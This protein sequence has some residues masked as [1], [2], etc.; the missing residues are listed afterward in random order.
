MVMNQTDYRDQ[1]REM[2]RDEGVY[3]VITDKRR[4]LTSRTEL[5][6]QQILLKL[7]KSGNLTESKCWKLR[8]FDS[9][10]PAFYQTRSQLDNWGGPYSYIRVHRL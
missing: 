10:S 2:L 7:K 4:N 1:I 3:K 5:E 6:L 9:Y 8:P